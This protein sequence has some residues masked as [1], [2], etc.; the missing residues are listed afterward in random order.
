[1]IETPGMLC[2]LLYDDGCVNSMQSR[3]GSDI[4][5]QLDDVV[6][7]VSDDAER[8]AEANERTLRWLDR[9]IKVGQLM[10]P[11]D[12]SVALHRILS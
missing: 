5:M 11:G 8:F 3:I 9:C 4:I 12:I 10:H 1:M 2:C 7:S 6:S